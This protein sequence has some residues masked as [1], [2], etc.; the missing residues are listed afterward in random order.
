MRAWASMQPWRQDSNSSICRLA[1]EALQNLLT[2]RCL[3]KTVNLSQAGNDPAA[4]SLPPGCRVI[5][6]EH[7]GTWKGFQ[8]TV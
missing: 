5:G 4:T 8:V 3:D 1:S 2:G 6:R 7:Q